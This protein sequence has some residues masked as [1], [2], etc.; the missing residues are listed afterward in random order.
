MELLLFIEKA[1]LQL[2]IELKIMVRIISQSDDGIFNVALDEI[3]R[4]NV[5]CFRS[6]TVYA[7][8]CDARNEK[9]IQRIYYLKNRDFSKPIAIYVKDLEMAKKIFDFDETLEGFCKKYF[10][11]YLTIVAK[12]S[13]E[14]SCII[15]DNLSLESNLIGFRIVESEFVNSIMSAL[16]SP[17]AVTSA[18]ISGSRNLISSKEVG[19]SFSNEDFLVVDSGEVSSHQVS[20]VVEYDKGE[21]KILRQGILR[22]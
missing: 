17:L 4:G 21:F 18:N 11:G 12:K 2:K 5:I 3:L 6:D 10:P 14:G 19:D 15:S 13:D 20:T 16:D 8:A 22:I 1:L 9:A 7:F